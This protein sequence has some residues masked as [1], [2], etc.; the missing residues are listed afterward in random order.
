MT[1]KIT[2]LLVLGLAL[3]S[4]AQT[5]L[6]RDFK[7]DLAKL[8]PEKL[9]QTEFAKQAPALKFDSAN[10]QS[11]Q[12]VGHAFYVFKDAAQ[13]LRGKT[14]EFRV[15]TKHLAG[16]AQ[17]GGT[18]RVSTSP[19][20]ELRVTK[21]FKLELPADN[22]FHEQVASFTVPN[23]DN[24]AHV[25][26]QIGFR[27]QGTEQNLWIID[28]PQF[29][30]AASSDS[31]QLP[32]DILGLAGLLDKQPLV[33]V[34][35]GEP[36]FSIVI[37][38]DADAIA[39]LAAEELQ[40]HC[41]L[42]TGKDIPI[43]QEKDGEEIAGAA[44]HIGATSVVK[45]FALEP[46]KLPPE[47]WLVAR[48]GQNILL[49]GGDI[50]NASR[51]QTLSMRGVATGTL[52]AAYEFLERVFDIRWY[53][54]GKYG[55]VAPKAENISLKRLL[56]TGTPS[57]S[58]RAFLY[59]IP[60][61]PDISTAEFT[62][63]YRRNRIGSSHGN[64]LANHSFN[65]WPKKHGSTHPEYFALQA[66]GRRKTDEV[67]GGHICLSNPEVLQETIREKIEYFKKYPEAGFSSVMPGDSFGLYKCICEDCQ[68]LSQP[69]RG[70]GGIDSNAVWGFVNKVALGVAEEMPERY[71]TCCAYG[72]YLRRPDFSLAPNVA[73]TLCYGAQ[74]RSDLVSKN[75]WRELLDEW[76]QTGAALYVW[77]YWNNSRYSRGVYGAPAIFPRHLQEFMRLDQGQVRGRALELSNIDGN[78][79]SFSYWTDWVYDALNIYVV[80][81]LMND[82]N[83][84][85][86][87]ILDRYYPEFYGPAAEPMRQ[88]HDEIELAWT[89]GNYSDGWNWENCWVKTYPP[90]FVDRMMALLRQSVEMC[91]GQEAYLARAKKTLEGYLPFE[92][93][94]FLFRE[95]KSKTNTLAITVPKTTE[96]PVIDGRLDEAAW[97]K[98]AVINNFCDSY[99]IY[100]QKA[101]TEMRFLTTADC[102]YVAVKAT[103]PPERTA[104]KWADDLGKHDSLLWNAESA[105]LFFVGQDQECYQFIIA[106][107][108]KLADFKWPAENTAEGL[109]WNAEGVQYE[110]IHDNESWTAEIAIPLHNLVLKN[111]P[112]DCSYI[113]NFARNHRYQD[114]QDKAWKWEQSCWLPTYGPFHSY[115]KF[116]KMTLSK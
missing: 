116:G 10:V 81:H 42:A 22:E 94:S 74:P 6:I 3:A 2:L 98:A 111:P 90:E 59:S 101:S 30:R 41:Q 47:S 29:L 44:I 5:A 27:Q 80:S 21:N 9:S 85:V 15:K 95:K 73:V 20:N 36:K 46:S 43:R 18:F 64:P 28:E 11:G 52:Y 57:Y 68:K 96:T 33:L 63:W 78:G 106:P 40:I 67:A 115:N 110:A 54:P 50:P 71:I 51:S 38:A 83:C 99:N 25:N 34:E 53:W 17:L 23:L 87:E 26:V 72:S 19:G 1:H 93:N 104:I 48:S 39:K 66:D 114:S 16:N 35:N 60:R 49:T 8:P 7:A 91:A 75:K 24:I 56:K 100:E 4:S 45:K 88:F 105:E 37:A 70:G 82:I 31:V 65:A 113:V 61:D 92:R 103:F 12:F 84:D 108:G 109:K 112:K 77:E 32:T 62:R 102:L 76:R 55:T 86:E 89:S 79:I 107:N 13:A 69:E 14:I 58:T 97:Q